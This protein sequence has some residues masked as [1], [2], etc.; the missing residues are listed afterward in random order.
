[1]LNKGEEIQ[2]EEKNI[3]TE[4]ICLGFFNKLIVSTEYFF[5]LAFLE[6]AITSKIKFNRTEITIS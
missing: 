2:I 1:M 5:N 3:C 4:L 6:L